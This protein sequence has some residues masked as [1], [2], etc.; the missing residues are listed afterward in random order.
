MVWV[1][2]P[3]QLSQN[4]EEELIYTDLD[5]VKNHSEEKGIIKK[6]SQFWMHVKYNKRILPKGNK[7]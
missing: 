3:P 7:I 4:S 1:E 5:S 6:K 2:E